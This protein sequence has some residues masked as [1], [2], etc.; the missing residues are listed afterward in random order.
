MLERYSGTFSFLISSVL[1]CET[2][3]SWVCQCKTYTQEDANE[4]ED[5]GKNEEEEG[6]LEEEGS[7][8]ESDEDDDKMVSDEEIDIKK[9]RY[10]E[11]T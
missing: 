1:K 9:T 7:D 8:K 10:E 3:I 4:E 2:L 6:E 11:F 5:D